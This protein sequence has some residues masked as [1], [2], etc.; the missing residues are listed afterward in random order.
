MPT[1]AA[2]LAA[3]R[4]RFS[5]S[6]TIPPIQLSGAASSVSLRVLCTLVFGAY[7]LIILRVL[8]IVAVGRRE[9]KLRQNDYGGA[10]RRWFS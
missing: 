5:R 1:S 8:L 6:S 4:N 2:S 7:A 9:R 3:E 10:P